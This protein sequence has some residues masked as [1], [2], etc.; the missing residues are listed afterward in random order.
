[1]VEALDM[2]VEAKD[3]GGTRQVGDLPTSFQPNLLRVSERAVGVRAASIPRNKTAASNSN[4]EDAPPLPDT[5]D[6]DLVS[7]HPFQFEFHLTS[8][9]NEKDFVAADI[10]QLAQPYLRFGRPDV[11]RL[12]ER[13]AAL[14]AD[15]G[16]A[17]VAVVTCGPRPMM[18]E[19]AAMCASRRG[20]VT[21]DLHK[22]VFDF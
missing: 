4:D 16:I 9:R 3:P 1:M 19:V 8:L 2:D 10:D 17:R 11:P 14:C 7:P 20:G 15:E 18:D 13:V 22:E 12:F 6:D 5:V 21:F